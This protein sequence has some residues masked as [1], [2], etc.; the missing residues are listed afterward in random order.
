[1][2]TVEHLR[3]DFTY[4]K[5]MTGLKGSLRNIFHRETLTKEAVRD[6]SFSVEQGEMVGFLGPNG[7]GKTTTLKILSGILFPTD[8]KVE[9]DGFVPGNERTRLKSAFPLLW[10]RKI[11]FGGIFPPATA[12]ISTN[13]CLRWTT[14]IT[15]IL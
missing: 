2:I 11:S 10:G 8:G 9:I 6:I 1:M 12:F 5:K 13:A 3:K 4:Y 14:A 7:A 15:G